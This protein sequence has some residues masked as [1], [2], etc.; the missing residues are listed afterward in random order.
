MVLSLINP[1]QVLQPS[2]PQQNNTNLG[3]VRGILVQ[4]SSA[5]R[6]TLNNSVNNI[7]SKVLSGMDGMMNTSRFLVNI[8][9]PKCFGQDST[10]ISDSEAAAADTASAS[11]PGFSKNNLP[12]LCHSVNVP[13]MQIDTQDVHPYGYGYRSKMP[14]GQTFPDVT[15]TFYGDSRLLS[16]NFFTKWLQYIVNF[17]GDTAMNGIATINDGG[18]FEIYYKDDYSTIVEI[19]LFDLRSESV[20]TYKLNGAYPIAISDVTL[21]WEN[22]DQLYQF[23]VTFAYDYWT[24]TFSKENAIES[25]QERNMNAFVG[26][27][28][29]GASVDG[30][31]YTPNY[32]GVYDSSAPQYMPSYTY[33]GTS[34]IVDTLAANT[35]MTLLNSIR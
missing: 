3:V 9:A 14:T 11:Q 24:S 32:S 13:G 6:N 28:T 22:S 27:I 35:L 4:Q 5:Q 1:D 33:Y 20:A 34:N 10:A 16:K 12:F 21:A 25:G 29:V 23:Q 8:T 18:P 30:R 2:N 15:C 7:R 19:T 26:G 31:N 17:N